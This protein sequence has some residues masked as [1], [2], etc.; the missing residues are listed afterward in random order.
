MNL[1]KLG[2]SEIC[3]NEICLMQGVGELKNYDGVKIEC[4]FRDDLNSIVYN[5]LLTKP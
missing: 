2:V 3:G 4:Y 5:A 1:L